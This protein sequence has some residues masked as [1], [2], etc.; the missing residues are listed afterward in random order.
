MGFRSDGR[1][2]AFLGSLGWVFKFRAI[3]LISGRK[4]LQYQFVNSPA[5]QSTPYKLINSNIIPEPIG[6]IRQPARYTSSQQHC[7][8]TIHDRPALPHGGV[9]NQKADWAGSMRGCI[10]KYIDTNC[11]V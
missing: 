3:E 1:D 4:R 2:L 6:Y 8:R 5:L 7:S 10:E 11:L 9:K